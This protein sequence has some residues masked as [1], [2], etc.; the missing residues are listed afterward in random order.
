MNDDIDRDLPM[1]VADALRDAEETLAVAESCT[2]GLVGATLTAIP[3][4]SDYFEAGLT[5]YAYGAKRRHLCVSREALDEHGAV[6]DPVAREMARGVRDACDV[7]WGLSITGV[8]GPTGGAEDTPVGTVYVGV[9][10]AGPWGSESSFADAERFEFDG[11]RAA[12]RAATV[13]RSLE[14]LLETA[15]RVER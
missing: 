3:G 2:G 11:D 10:Y 4:A 9:A 14:C 7:T 1:R 15:D 5:T 13:E 12:I 6:S 8:A